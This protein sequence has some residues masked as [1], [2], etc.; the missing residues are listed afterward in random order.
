MESSQ[1]IVVSN[2]RFQVL[3]ESLV[4]MEYCESGGF[5][6][7]PTVSVLNRTDWPDV[8]FE[9]EIADG[10]LHIRAMDLHL[11]YLMD[12]GMFSADNL[13]ISWA[14]GHD[15]HVWHPG[16]VDDANLGG[17]PPTMDGVAEFV[18]SPG[19]LS[20]KG[21]YLLDDSRSPIRDS[22][23]QWIVPRN[24]ADSQD[25]YFFVYRSNYPHML[26][27]LSALLGPIPM[28]PRYMLGAWFTSRADYAQN[29]WQMIVER[30]REESLPLDILVLDSC[31]WTN[32]I[33][34][35]YDWD[36][37]QL[38]DPKGFFHWAKDH[39][40][41]VSINEHYAALT[42]ENEHN[43]DA[44]R[45]T[46]GWGDDVNEITHDLAAQK[47]A[48]LFM[49]ML[50]TPAFDMGLAFWWQDGWAGA[51]MEGLDPAMWT[52]EIEYLGSEA[53]T[54][55]RSFMFCRLGLAW[56]AHRYGSYF[57]GDM[58]SNWPT[59]ALMVDSAIKGGNMLV[60]WVNHDVGAIFGVKIDDEMYLRWLQFGAFSPIFRLHSLWG[61]RLPWEYGEAG[62]ECY[63]KFTGLRYSLLPYIYTYSRLAHETGMPL[64]S[65]MYILYPDQ[66][67][68]YEFPLQFMFGR[69][70]LV[71]P[72][73]ESGEGNPVTKDVFLPA[74]DCWFDYLTR[75]MY[76]GGQVVSYMCP[77]DRMPIFVRA[78][79][80]IPKAPPMDFSDQKAVDP[81]TLDIYAGRD[82]EFRL[83]E[84]D[85]ISLDYRAGSYS[86]TP[87]RFSACES[88]GDYQ[89][90]I[91]AAE[92][93]Y[94][95][96]LEARRY[97]IRVHGLLIPE[98]VAVNGAA[99]S[100]L[101]DDDCGTGWTW[102]RVSRVLTIW[103]RSPLP[104]SERITI[105]V[106]NV[107]AMA[108]SFV[109]QGALELRERVRNVKFLE[110]L[111]YAALLN[112]AEHCKPPRVIRKTE[113]V[114]QQLNQIVAD[115]KGIG[116]NQPNFEAMIQRVVD[117]FTDQP[118][119]SKRT[120]PDINESARISEAAIADG[121]FSEE[122]L[123]SMNSIMNGQMPE[124][125]R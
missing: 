14:D 100:Q 46:M 101:R 69:E 49:N 30:F 95:G 18:T 73:T 68:S 106:A 98:S 35:G 88:D 74:G 11:K 7:A 38:P 60:A 66:E 31:S 26:Q 12:S 125:D 124:R 76:S 92:G 97:V 84:D 120:I 94:P 9:S 4:R 115:P 77:I 113:E 39:G 59:L 111:K 16:D 40:L 62:I 23:S 1:S 5:V 78:G 36:Y 116:R 20:R 109:L 54:G 91:G 114:E 107:G 64:L 75:S 51:D 103:L 89:I 17:V 53:I 42:A 47:Y 55:K 67:R 41:R 29:Q 96:Q 58:T 48:D 79:S 71:A 3:S 121:A 21:C 2:A 63:K 70:I 87:L 108:D 102:D 82:A 44:I 118:F 28:I 122:E 61:M 8:N 50:H 15:E 24:R 43:F 33:W 123:N 13:R 34:A 10:W 112:G 90:R 45:K 110:K 117:S 85:G 81:L 6:D 56:G 104:I 27:E 57:T 86:W 72:I 105:S 19:A 99:L 32:A 25:W 83:Y 119:E 93:R 52:R 22:E 65:G 37:E 80:I